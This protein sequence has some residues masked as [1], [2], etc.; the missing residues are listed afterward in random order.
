M[1][2]NFPFLFFPL[3]FPFS[4][5]FFRFFF[6]L[7]ISPPFP[8]SRGFFLVVPSDS[9]FLA[10]SLSLSRCKVRRWVATTAQRAAEAGR[11][12]ARGVTS[13]RDGARRHRRGSVRARRRRRG[14]GRGRHTV[15][16]PSSSVREHVV[17]VVPMP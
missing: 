12:I 5:F 17:V 15:E 11:L 4:F 3:F 14:G 10:F 6:P 7:P 16:R 1:F 13:G 9:F 8:F 2:S